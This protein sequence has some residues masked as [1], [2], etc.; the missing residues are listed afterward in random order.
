MRRLATLAGLV[1]TCTLPQ[2]V[3][4]QQSPL[5]GSLV[6]GRYA[7]G[8]TR[9]ELRDSTRPD[10]P[11]I[12]SAGRVETR[13]RSR[14]LTVHIWYPAARSTAAAMT[15]ADY[16]SSHFADTAGQTARQATEANVR[17]FLNDFGPVSDSAWS[18]LRRT[19]LLGRRNATAASGRFPLVVGSLRRFST[20]GIRRLAR[21]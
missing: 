8:F 7:V 20:T 12:D 21:A 15:F 4:A 13:D 16:M 3:S 17:R 18:A 11:K 9:R 5:F 1:A 10:L 19:P 14:L 2:A 6:P